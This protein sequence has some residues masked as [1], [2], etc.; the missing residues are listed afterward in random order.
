MKSLE[1]HKT[2]TD[3]LSA[4]E[5]KL[6]A[7]YSE[8]IV[9]REGCSSCCILQSVFPVDAYIIYNAVTSGAVD[10]SSLEFDETPGMCAFLKNGLCSV[11]AARP[12]ICRT[13]GYPV[14]VEGS[15]DFCP[16]NFSGVKSIESEHILDLENLNM[17]VAS[18]NILFQKETD[19]GFF[20]KE[21]ITMS[22]LKN[23]ILSLK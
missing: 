1:L 7:R 18:I 9:C 19:D 2:L 17:A 22:E 20:Q 13:H 10:R 16:K 5:E 12:V 23:Y 15:I 3:K 8:Q 11:Y 14:L 4:H 21:R 6:L